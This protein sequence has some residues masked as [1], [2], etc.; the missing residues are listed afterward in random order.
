MKDQLEIYRSGEHYFCY[1]NFFSQVSLFLIFC[2]SFHTDLAIII[3]ILQQLVSGSLISI[4][5]ATVIIPASANVGKAIYANANVPRYCRNIKFNME[6]ATGSAAANRLLRCVG[7]RV[8]IHLV[9]QP[10]GRHP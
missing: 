10:R 9:L 7:A 2:L 5:F 8:N 3:T 6:S 4:S 1:S